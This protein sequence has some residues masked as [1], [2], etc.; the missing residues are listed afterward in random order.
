MTHLMAQGGLPIQERVSY[1]NCTRLQDMGQGG[2][3]NVAE[4]F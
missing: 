4:G 3:A 2:E 1:L